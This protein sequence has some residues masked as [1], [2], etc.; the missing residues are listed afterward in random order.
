MNYIKYLYIYFF[1]ILTASL[2]ALFIPN[3]TNNYVPQYFCLATFPVFGILHFL[4]KYWFSRQ[5]KQKLPLLFK[6]WAGEIGFVYARGRFVDLGLIAKAD[7]IYLKEQ[8]IFEMYLLC[9]HLFRLVIISFI[10]SALL[11]IVTVYI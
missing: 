10:L 3:P 4:S 8:Q 9:I 11:G 6:K 2:A 1:T 7:F 5:I